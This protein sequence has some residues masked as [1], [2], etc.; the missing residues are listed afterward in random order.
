[1]PELPEVETVAK[2]LRPLLEGFSLEAVT[3]NS[4]GLRY[5][6][7]QAFAEQ[8]RGK[9]ISRVARRAKY[10][11]LHLSDAHTVV[12]HLGMSGAFRYAPTQSYTPEKHDHAIWQLSSGQTV[13]YNDPRRFGAMDI[14]H[15]AGLFAH[16]WLKDIGAEPLDAAAF[17]AHGFFER[18]QRTRRAVKLALLDQ[19]VVAGIGNIYASES[20]YYAG[21]HPLRSADSLS[22]NEAASLHASVVNVLTAAIS[23][24]GSTLRDYRNPEG[25]LGCFQHRF[26]VYDRAGLPCPGCAGECTVQLIRQGGRSTYFCGTRQRL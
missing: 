5:P 6:W 2:G 24:G 13:A 16:P 3:L 17:T 10:L 7:P 21:I 9:T 8:L 20:L 15:T 1:M 19:T 14:T 26:A 22:L 18:L 11:L 25:E 4:K 12:A 23:A